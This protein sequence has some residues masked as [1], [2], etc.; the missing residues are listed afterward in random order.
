MRSG[1]DAAASRER[2]RCDNG[3][4]PL[5]APLSAHDLRLLAH[6][7]V[8]ALPK[9][10]LALLRRHHTRVIDLFRALDKNLDG[11]LTRQEL[12]HALTCLGVKLNQGDVGALFEGLITVCRKGRT[13]AKEPC[14]SFREV[15]QALLNGSES[16]THIAANARV[17]K[18]KV[19]VERQNEGLRAWLRYSEEARQQAEAR[20][21]ALQQEVAAL[22]RKVAALER[23]LGNCRAPDGLGMC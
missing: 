2:T 14:L 4:A 12:S 13:H 22:R 21:A 9:N 5:F 23:E 3:C 11:E 6:S 7:D 19:T 20:E 18:Q 10:L 8:A 16:S 15:Q 1:S 17:R